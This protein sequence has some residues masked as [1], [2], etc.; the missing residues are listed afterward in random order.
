MVQDL[1]IDFSVEKVW[2]LTEW[3][4]LPV[5]CTTEGEAPT[6]A[7]L[8]PPPLSQRHRYGRLA[9]RTSRLVSDVTDSE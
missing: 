2:L 7:D 8:G 1:F 9:P 6:L 4:L 3:E 5:S